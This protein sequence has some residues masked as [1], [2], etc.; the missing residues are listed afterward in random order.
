MIYPDEKEKVAR[1]DWNRSRKMWIGSATVDAHAAS[2][3]IVV[4]SR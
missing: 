4:T 1:C 3:D 2:G